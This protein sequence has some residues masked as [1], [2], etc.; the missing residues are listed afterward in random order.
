MQNSQTILIVEDENIN[1]LYLNAS[2]KTFALN[3]V[4]IHAKNGK[5]ALDIVEMNSDI[6]LIL[7][8]LKMPIMSGFEATKLIKKVRPNLP[9]IAQTAYVSVSDRALAK[10]IGC[11]GFLPKPINKEDLLI[12]LKQYLT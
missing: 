3:V 5:E 12:V 4:C 10:T 8:D 11:D 7:M 6:D 1:Y 2:I 9:I